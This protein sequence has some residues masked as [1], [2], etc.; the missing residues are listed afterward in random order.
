MWLTYIEYRVQNDEYR[1]CKHTRER[2]GAAA[3]D[4][5]IASW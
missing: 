2:F 4:S 5:F 3:D 1:E